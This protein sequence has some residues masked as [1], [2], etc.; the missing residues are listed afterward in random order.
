MEQIQELDSG[1]MFK[2]TDD[3]SEGVWLPAAKIPGAIHSDLMHNG[4]IPHP[5]VDMNELNARWVSERSWTYR[6]YFATPS[7]DVGSVTD[8][9]FKGLDTLATVWLNGAKILEADNMFVE[10]RVN[11]TGKLIPKSSGANILKIEFSSAVLRGREMV[12]EHE[13]EHHFIAHQTEQGRLPIRK[14]QYQWG[15][16]W[17]PILVTAGIWR[18]IFLHTYVSRVDDV[19]F[20]IMVSEDLKSVSGKLFTQVSPGRA[21]RVRFTLA[22]DGELVLDKNSDTDERGQASC[23]FRLQDPALWYPAGLGTAA[24]YELKA[25]IV[26]DHR[27]FK[28]KL[29]GFRRVELIQ[30]PDGYGTS[31]FFRINNIDVFCGGACWIPADSFLSVTTER[32]CEWIQLLSRGNQ[33]MVRVWGGGIYED[34]SFF[35][36]CD[37]LGILVWQDFCMACQ[38]TP[39]YHS[40]LSSL[41]SEARCNIRRLRTHPSLIIWAGNNED[42]EIQEAYNLDY[43]YADGDPSSWLR[44]SFPARYVY[45]YLLPKILEQE[46]PGAIYHPSSPWSHGK[47]TTDPTVG[48]IHQWNIWHRALKPY[49]EAPNLSGRFVSEFG[50][51]AYPHL[52]TIKSM[53]TDPEQ[54]YP[55]SM[56]MDFHNR[57]IDHERKLVTYIAENFRV[58]Y[59]LAKFTHLTQLVQADALSH[60]YKSWRRQWGS[61]GRRQ[62]GGVLVWQLNDCWPT[63]SWAVVDYYLVPKPGFY[64]IQRALTS[65]AV[66]VARPFHPWTQGHVD[67]TI[68]TTDRKYEIWIASRELRDREVELQVRYISI[69]TGKDVAETSTRRVKVTAN[70]TTEV[71]K[72]EVEVM[73]QELAHEKIVP[74][75]K[76]TW[77][78][79]QAS[80]FKFPS[81]HKKGVPPFSLRNNDPYIIFAKVIGEAGEVLSSDTSWPDP[82]KYLNWES[83]GIKVEVV[84]E[85]GQVVKI[86]AQKPVKG[87]VFQEVRGGGALSDNGFDVMPGEVKVVRFER[88]VGD[89]HQLRWTFLGAKKIEET[90]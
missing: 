70:A 32:Y 27:I 62:C 77:V 20:Q 69:R 74:E 89:G 47:K 34:D 36:A 38:S 45:E 7:T 73:V 56:L 57:A 83:R 85:T 16:D 64:A 90:L 39:T 33:N 66:G 21:F 2:D 59:S 4:Q 14:A 86:T 10:Y 87:F 80:D 35:D 42:Y 63:M 43:D 82:L 18:P 40:F 9:V 58:D 15:W 41:E 24:R 37:E 53:V 60:S 78:T 17:G 52:Q 13:H 88:A 79:N 30:E 26:S 72:G 81:R 11:V 55:G 8:L 68:A 84:G 71:I 29:I 6:L 76:K 49:Q 51:E 3:E 25:S 67:P 22:K 44:S 54:Q 75:D 46:D 28:S 48:D 65:I 23:T 1:W 19:W 5:L 61:S 12:K 31:F 50:M